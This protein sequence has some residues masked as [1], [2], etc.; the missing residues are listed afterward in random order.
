MYQ[1]V[2]PD[3]P[4]LD[5][6]LGE[7]VVFGE[8]VEDEGQIDDR[9]RVGCEVQLEPSFQPMVVHFRKKL[10]WLRSV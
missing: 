7:K 10:A 9:G 3:S 2:S 5:V 6:S 1:R 8:T 4:F